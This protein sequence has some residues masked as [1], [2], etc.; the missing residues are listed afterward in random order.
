MPN[1]TTEDLLVYL[2]A[3]MEPGKACELETALQSDWALQ[4]KFNVMKEAQYQ[5]D[6]I[7]IASPRSV[8]IASILSYAETSIHISN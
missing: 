5:L 1:F 7:P 3:E 4:Q 8:T 2:Y 6:E